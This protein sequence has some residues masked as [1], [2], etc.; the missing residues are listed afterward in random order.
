MHHAED[1]SHIS[2]RL[3]I[4]RKALETMASIASQLENARDGLVRSSL[5]TANVE[6][7]PPGVRRLWESLDKNIMAMS[8]IDLR[9]ELLQIEQHLSVRLV[10]LTPFIEK[11]CAD[12]TISDDAR[13]HDVQTQ[14]QDLAR[15]ASTA[16]AIRMLAHRKN[17]KFSPSELPIRAEVLREKA[18]RVKKIERTHKLRVVNHMRDMTKATTTMLKS[19]GLDAATHAMLKNVLRDLQLNAKHLANGGSFSSLPVP[20]EEVEMNEPEPEAADLALEEEKVAHEIDRQTA[21]TDIPAGAAAVVTSVFQAPT[22]PKTQSR[23]HNQIASS[24]SA[25][26][27]TIAKPPRNLGTLGGVSRPLVQ[28]NSVWRFFRQF[29]VWLKSPL[30]VTW[31]EAAL[32]MHEEDY[33]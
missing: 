4:G 14:M 2:Q 24:I 13:I 32:L 9:N 16:L 27:P 21:H 33:E 1:S 3:E 22:V 6:D 18:E 28:T 7:L 29:H 19:P 5:L 15:L 23:I 10:W 17:Y 26:A 31:R 20:I 12:E 25:I 11:I 30:N 8:A